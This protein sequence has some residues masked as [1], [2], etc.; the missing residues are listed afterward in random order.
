MSSGVKQFAWGVMCTRCG[1][2]MRV[3]YPTNEQRE[4]IA[5]HDLPFN[6]YDASREEIDRFCPNAGKSFLVPGIDCPEIKVDAH[7]K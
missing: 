5:H 4:V 2:T 6:L 7:T 1:F 3:P